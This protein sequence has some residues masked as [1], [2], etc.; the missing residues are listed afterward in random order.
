MIDKSLNSIVSRVCS[1]SRRQGPHLNNK[2]YVSYRIT[3]GD[4]NCAIGRDYQHPYAGQQG[5]TTFPV[6]FIRGTLR[7]K[8]RWIS[9]G[10]SGTEASMGIVTHA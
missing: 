5:V 1:I 6:A 10:C 3:F 8:F 2:S 7:E 9:T 4:V